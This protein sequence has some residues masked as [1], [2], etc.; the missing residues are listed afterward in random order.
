MQKNSKK[1][2]EYVENIYSKLQIYNWTTLIVHTKK[3]KSKVK[4][5]LMGVFNCHLKTDVQRIL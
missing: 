5:L 1:L 2:I 4:A 3:R